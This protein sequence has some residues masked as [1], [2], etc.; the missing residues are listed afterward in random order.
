M[1]HADLRLSSYLEHIRHAAGFVAD[2]LSHCTQVQFEQQE[3]L[4]LAVQ[5]SIENIGEAC[6]QIELRFPHFAAEHPELPMKDAYRMRNML[7]HAYYGVDV[8]TLWSTA[9]SDLPLFGSAATVLL[10]K[11]SSG[12]QR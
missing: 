4:R 8:E 10:E 7:I 6:H 11:M 2:L 1:K 5:K 9:H 12:E 3:V